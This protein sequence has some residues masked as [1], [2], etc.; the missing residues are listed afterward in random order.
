L[1]SLELFD[2]LGAAKELQG[3]EAFFVLARVLDPLQ[4][5]LRAFERYVH[6]IQ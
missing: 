5:V 1:I 3:K 2:V 4:R 6:C